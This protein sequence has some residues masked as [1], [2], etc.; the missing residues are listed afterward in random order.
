MSE[1]LMRSDNL[2]FN[3]EQFYNEN[4]DRFNEIMSEAQTLFAGVGHLYAIK[5]RIKSLESL[6]HKLNRKGLEINSGYELLHSIGD[7]V[8]IR[9]IYL[10]GVDFLL[11]HDYIN[12]LCDR[13]ILTLVSK[14]H[15]YTY[16]T[17]E[18]TFYNGLGVVPKLKESRYTSVHYKVRLKGYEDV[19][20]EIQVRSLFEEAWCEIDHLVN[21][22]E[23]NGNRICRDSLKELAGL[24][25]QS[26]KLVDTIVW[27]ASL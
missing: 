14:P 15:A 6:Q 9:L 5:G 10:L 11:I 16:D 21:Y 23:K 7:I 4:M 13:G 12:D 17:A 24:V 1:Y 8:G 25:H 26:N 27:E 3:L 22:P 18:D 19:C 2:Q 20:F